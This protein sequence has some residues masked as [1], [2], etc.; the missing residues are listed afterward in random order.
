[1]KPFVI[2]IIITLIVFGTCS[3]AYHLYLEKN[4]RK[5]L[6]AVDSSFLMQ[7][8]W[9]QVPQALEAIA[10]RRYT[11]FSLVTEKNRIH[12]WSPNL[13]LGTLVPYA[14]QDFLKLTNS[15]E[16]PE[17]AE[18]MQKYLITTNIEASQSKDFKGWIIIQLT[19]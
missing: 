19:P 8:V 14:P 12:S 5:I 2:W 10:N 4:P 9:P 7:A 18:A 1:M 11:V 15:T 17:I 3:A 6:V 13:Q 16:Y